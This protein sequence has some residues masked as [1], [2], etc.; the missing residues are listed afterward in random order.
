[1]V[2]RKKKIL[3]AKKND[4]LDKLYVQCV[5]ES[6]AEKRKPVDEIAIIRK[7]LYCVAHGE[8]PS[9][10]LIKEFDEYYNDVEHIKSEIKDEF[11]ITR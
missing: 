9:D 4:M 3:L 10:E 1:M 2:D 11:G 8:K 5:R 6:V 7:M